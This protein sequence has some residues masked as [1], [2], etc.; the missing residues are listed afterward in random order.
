MK[1]RTRFKTAM[2]GGIF[3]LFI[4]LMGCGGGGDAGGGSDASGNG[5]TRLTPP[6]SSPDTLSDTF[7]F[8]TGMVPDR[9][10]L[11]RLEID[12]DIEVPPD[13]T[14]T[15]NGTTI[16]GNVYVNRGARLIADNADIIGNVQAY[17]SDLVDLGNG[18]YVEGDVQGKFTASVI[19][20]AT[21][22]VGGNVQIVEANTSMDMDALRVESAFVDGDVQTE[23]S[24]GRLRVVNSNVG[25]NVQFVENW[26]GPYTI[27]DN[28]IEGDLQFFKNQGAG[29]ITG[30]SV[31]GNLQSKENNP[32][33]TIADNIVRGDLEDE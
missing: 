9:E 2:A 26:T 23:K 18:T 27:V 30:N 17:R 1:N 29:T 14:L 20:G 33:P 28:A 12:D 16:K 24:R 11:E 13:S 15:L 8:N 7:V 10:V 32:R 22:F 25:G 5:T 31:D 6:V 3:L 21:V 19:V 4:A